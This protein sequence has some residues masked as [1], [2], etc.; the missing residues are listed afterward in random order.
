MMFQGGAENKAF[1]NGFESRLKGNS[2]TSI[3]GRA[4]MK[5]WCFPLLEHLSADMLLALYKFSLYPK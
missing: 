2:R 5:V 1:K 3:P 4:E